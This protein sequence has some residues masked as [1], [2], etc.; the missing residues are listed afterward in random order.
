MSAL[1]IAAVIPAYQA[2]GTVPYVIEDVLPVVPELLVIDDGSTDGTGDAARSAGARVL[3]HTKNRGKGAALK[4]AFDDLFGRGV[5]AVV[6]LDADRQ[7]IPTEIPRLTDLAEDADLV[8]GVRDHLF[9]E[10]SSLRRFSNS[11]SSRLISFAAGTH[12]SDAQTGFRLYKRRLLE[13]V[14]WNETGFDAESAVVVRS[15]RLGY[16]IVGVPIELAKVDGRSTSHFRPLA[17]S[18]RIAR[19]VVRARIAPNR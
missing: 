6:T 19:A 14:S 4:T 10:M 12:I 15:A 5:D 7:H 8:L 3:T 13:N 16:K 2:A 11:I 17:D 1:R 9:G 18:A